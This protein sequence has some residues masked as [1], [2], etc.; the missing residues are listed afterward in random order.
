[1]IIEPEF[2]TKEELYNF[3]AACSG[4]GV[5]LIFDEIISGF[6]CGMGGLQKVHDVIPD[7]STFGKAI[8]N[9]MPISALVGK[10]EFMKQMTEISYSGTFFG[11]T[12]SIA[13]AIA[14]ID[15]LHNLNIPGY[16]HRIGDYLRTEINTMLNKHH[17]SSIISLHGPVEL[18]RIR[19][20]DKIVQS[21]FIQEMAKNGV[22][23]IGSH[24]TSYA[25][26]K[27]ELDRILSAWDATLKEIAEGSQLLGAIIQ[28]RSVR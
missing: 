20:Q 26:K 21:L 23:I 25:H 12:L 8:A 5:I 11:E 9:G 28:G 7:L 14:T 24:N 3:R 2:Y 6:R 27:P 22:L 16:L 13:A 17:L 10:K 15:K 4:Y 18:N 1:M 19:F